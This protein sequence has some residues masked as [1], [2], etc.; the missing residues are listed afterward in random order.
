ML[1]PGRVSSTGRSTGASQIE[2]GATEGDRPT[3][4]A[5]Q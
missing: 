2:A 1:I 5:G 3:V 4:E